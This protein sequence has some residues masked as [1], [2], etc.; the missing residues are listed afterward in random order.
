MIKTPFPDMIVS[1]LAADSEYLE[2]FYAVLRKINNSTDTLKANYLDINPRDFISFPAVIKDNNIICFSGV[3]ESISRW[4]PNIAR[5]STRMWIDYDYRHV[6]LT[7][8]KG[9]SK[10]LNTTHCMPIQIQRAK[11]AGVKCLFISREGNKKLG[12]DQ[13]L[14]LIKINNNIEFELLDDKYNTCGSIDPIPES[15]KQFVAIHTLAV[16]GKEIWNQQ[17]ESKKIMSHTQYSTND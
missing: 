14:K 15:C 13:Y 8:F 17:M 12:F 11:E 7:K 1:D 4:G 16:D 2:L 6:G 9:G 10:F 5:I 3:A